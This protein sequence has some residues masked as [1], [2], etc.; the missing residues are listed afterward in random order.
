MQKTALAILITLI[1]FSLYAQLPDKGLEEMYDYQVKGMGEFMAR[2]NGKEH[3]KMKR[4]FSDSLSQRAKD[5][6]SVCNYEI[7]ETTP[8]F[9]HIFEKFIKTIEHDSIMLNFSDS[10]WFAA[11]TFN[12]QYQKKNIKVNLLLTPHEA[13]PNRFCWALVDVGG[14]DINKLADTTKWVGISPTDNELDFIELAGKS[15]TQRG[16][17]PGF[18]KPGQDIDYLSA[19]VALVQAGVVS[20]D[21]CEKITYY[22]LNVPDFVFTVDNF[23]R[24][25]SNSGWLI[26]SIALIAEEEK[27]P[28]LKEMFNY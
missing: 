27:Q 2:F 22:F 17:F 4:V 19:F 28:F 16:N 6:M 18:R 10:T 9:R 1:T 24:A 23:I 13:R 21:N 7:S 11:A 25:S 5:I 26:S 20:I 3:L 15:K 8:N 14:K 12:I